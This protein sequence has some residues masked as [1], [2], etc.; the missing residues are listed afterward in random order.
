MSVPDFATEQG[1][2]AGTLRGGAT[3]GKIL[4]ERR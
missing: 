3:F 4:R 2:R 1:D